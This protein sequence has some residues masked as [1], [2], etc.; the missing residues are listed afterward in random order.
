MA[1]KN[2]DEILKTY[3]QLWYELISAEPKSSRYDELFV[4]VMQF[5]VEHKLKKGELEQGRSWAEQQ[6]HR[7][8]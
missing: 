5:E 3:G 2:R 7:H 1:K 6:R 8:A 4:A